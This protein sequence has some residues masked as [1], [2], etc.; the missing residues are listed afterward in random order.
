MQTIISSR[1]FKVFTPVRQEFESY[2]SSF[3]R[4]SWKI[5]KVE[6]VLNRSH[7]MFHVEMILTGK[8]IWI[9]ADCED[10]SLGKA[11]ISA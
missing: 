8:G 3:D 7:D 4:K 1:H 9:E 11:F 2:L 6:V 5:N 10:E